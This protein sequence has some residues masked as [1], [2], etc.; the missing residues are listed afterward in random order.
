MKGPVYRRGAKNVLWLRALIRDAVLPGEG[1]T[2]CTSEAEEL[3]KAATDKQLCYMYEYYVE[4]L[5]MQTI[6]ELHGVAVSSVSRAI[7]RGE[8]KADCIFRSQP[9]GMSDEQ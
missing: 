2:F 9:G 4:E 8:R 3:H 1:M 7:A 6:A 5:R